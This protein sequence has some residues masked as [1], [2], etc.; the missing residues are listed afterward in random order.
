MNNILDIAGLDDEKSEI[1]REL[2]AIEVINQYRVTYWKN[3]QCIL[4]VDFL[5]SLSIKDRLYEKPAGYEESMVMLADVIYLNYKRLIHHID[6][7][8][9]KSI[10]DGLKVVIT[11][12]NLLEVINKDSATHIMDI[13]IIE[14]SNTTN[15]PLIK[16][17]TNSDALLSL[18]NVVYNVLIFLEKQAIRYYGGEE[19]DYLDT[20]DYYMN[21]E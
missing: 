7:R 11:P 10:I 4:S 20:D 14:I 12:D 1:K 17:L 2:V 21:N 5:K 16:V 19:E 9:T 8:I 18:S 3:S 6:S 15:P 13:G